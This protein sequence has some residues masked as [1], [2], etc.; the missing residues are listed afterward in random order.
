MIE[1]FVEATEWCIW[2]GGAFGW[3]V[4][5]NPWTEI[6]WAAAVSH[7]SELRWALSGAVGCMITKPVWCA[8][9][10][11][12][13]A[14]S[15]FE[16]KW[17]GLCRTCVRCYRISADYVRIA[18][19]TPA[20]RHWRLYEALFQTPIVVLEDEAVSEAGLGRLVHR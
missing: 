2:L 4:V 6:A 18:E 16:V 12:V 1:L 14:V 15:A 11:I 8:L 7:W 19:S 3:S 17:T 13:G 20:V 9:G 5:R 10:R